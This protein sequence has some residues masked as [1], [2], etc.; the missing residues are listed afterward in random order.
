MGK[1][2][3]QGIAEAMGIVPVV[4]PLLLRLGPMAAKNIVAWASVPMPHG[5]STLFFVCAARALL[6][7]CTCMYNC[8]CCGMC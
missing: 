5:V 7:Q 6:G 1:L 3:S 8:A 2:P 4:P